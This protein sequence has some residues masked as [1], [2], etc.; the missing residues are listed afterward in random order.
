MSSLYNR[1]F[2]LEAAASD[3][4]KLP[5]IFKNNTS[6][7]GN[8]SV[9]APGIRLGAVLDVIDLVVGTIELILDFWDVIVAFIANFFAVPYLALTSYATDVPFGGQCHGLAQVKPM[10]RNSIGDSVYARIALSHDQNQ[11]SSASS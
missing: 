7:T 2:T 3:C 10:F 1:E 6:G 9:I 5:L 4:F 8:I 11:P